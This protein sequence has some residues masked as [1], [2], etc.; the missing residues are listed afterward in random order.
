MP[1]DEW[2][3]LDALDTAQEATK[4]FPDELKTPSAKGLE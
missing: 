1:R 4:K 3:I 2:K